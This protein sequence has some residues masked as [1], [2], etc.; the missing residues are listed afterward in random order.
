MMKKFHYGW[1]ILALIVLSILASLGFG[2]FAFGA[3]IPFMKDGLD[4]DYRQTGFIASAVFMGYLISNA[5]IGYFVIR[6]DAKK[7]INFSLIVLAGSMILTANAIGFWS[8]YTG[9]L[10]IGLGSG[11][12][13]V[14]SL[15]LIG[16]WFSNKHRGMAMGAAM[17]GAGLGIVFSGLVVPFI[18]SFE[19]FEGWRI[20]WY[21]LGVLIFV[22]FILNGVFI[23]NH[24]KDVGV[25]PIGENQT[26]KVSHRSI[27]GLEEKD[28]S[29]RVYRNKTLWLLGFI[30][31]SWGFSYLIYSTFLVDYLIT[32]LNFDENT[33]GHFF[34]AGGIASI[35]SGFIWGMASDRLG[36]MKALSFVF[37]IETTML[38]GMS[39]TKEPSMLFIQV[40]V[41]G[42]TL[43]AVP[44]IMNASVGDFVQTKF[45]PV[46]MGFITLLFGVGQL[47][48]PIISGFLIDTT[49]SYFS[50]FIVSTIVCF[51][52]GCGCIKLHIDQKRKR[53]LKETTSAANIT[54]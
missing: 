27:S 43:W 31:L 22:I 39:I 7:V 3:I 19:A 32:D 17:G 30:F 53:I 24:P 36:R 51:T 10:L 6:Y 13:F 15:G 46:G 54:S 28:K 34:A 12:A 49:D 11:G 21:I 25:L 42:L 14:P 44:T 16:K 9:C 37:F 20:S 50:V 23:R 40:I 33:A 18:V 8:A 41:F 29:N 52:G 2:R 35:I 1:F 48:S 4:F 47:I 38:L 5:I 45:V 26:N